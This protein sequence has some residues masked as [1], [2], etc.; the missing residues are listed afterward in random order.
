LPKNF[1]FINQSYTFLVAYP[2][3]APFHFKS[4]CLFPRAHIGLESF[5]DKSFWSL[6]IGIIMSL[7]T[8]LEYK[9]K[10]EYSSFIFDISKALPQGVC[11]HNKR[12]HKVCNKCLKLWFY[13]FEKSQEEHNKLEFQF[14]FLLKFHYI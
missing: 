7:A 12:N 2:C 3:F 1:N 13:I 5:N 14:P 9:M 8:N 4:H 10:L 11:K 6:D